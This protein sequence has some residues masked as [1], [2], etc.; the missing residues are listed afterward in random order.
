MA[1]KEKINRFGIP[2]KIED[3]KITNLSKASSHKNVGFSFSVSPEFKREFKLY[4]ARKDLTMID[5]LIKAFEEYKQ[6]NP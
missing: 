1:K 3:P 2:P 6:R 5:V 4:A